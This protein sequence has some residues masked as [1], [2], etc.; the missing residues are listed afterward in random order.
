MT[1]SPRRMSTGIMKSSS[2][3]VI[4]MVVSDTS[5]TARAMSGWNT[6]PAAVSAKTIAT[7][8]SPRPSGPRLP[9][10][11]RIRSAMPGSSR[12]SSVNIVRVR[13]T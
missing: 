9:F 3:P 2:A 4:A 12:V 7:A 6:H 8:S 10:S 1:N 11:A 5:G 13:T